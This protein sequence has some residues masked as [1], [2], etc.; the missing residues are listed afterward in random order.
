MEEAS[1]VCETLTRLLP[2]LNGRVGQ[3]VTLSDVPKPTNGR[4]CHTLQC[5]FRHSTGARQVSAC[6]VHGQ[7]R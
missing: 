5:S 6:F 7:A 2:I 4:F 3:S 1:A